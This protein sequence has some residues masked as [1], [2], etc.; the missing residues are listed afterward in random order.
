MGLRALEQLPCVG[1]RRLAW[2]LAGHHFG[3]FPDAIFVRQHTNL[4]D[5]LAVGGRADN[6]L[7]YLQVVVGTSRYLRQV[8]DADDLVRSVLHRSLHGRGRPTRAG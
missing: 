2:L 3:Q 5:S 1:Y 7:G 8:S 4:G 6:R